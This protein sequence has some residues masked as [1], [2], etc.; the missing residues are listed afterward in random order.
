MAR[1][2]RDQSGDEFPEV[3]DFLP[4]KRGAIRKAVIKEGTAAVSTSRQ[5]LARERKKGKENESVDVRD[6]REKS[7]GS[8]IPAQKPKPRKRILKHTTDNPLLRPLTTTTTASSSE[9]SVRKSKAKTI[10]VAEKEIVL[11]PRQ[12]QPSRLKPKPEKVVEESESDGMSD[13]IVSDDDSAA[14]IG[15]SSDEEVVKTP[16]RSVRRLVRGRRPVREETP[17][18][19]LEERLGKGESDDESEE[20]DLAARIKKLSVRSRDGEDEMRKTSPTKSSSDTGLKKLS[21]RKELPPK[22]KVGA[23]SRELNNPFSTHL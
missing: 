1:L 15:E 16:P 14:F 7:M 9:L 8:E 12:T 13:F 11:K 18:D 21:T 20:D 3:S 2:A 17:E 22:K 5:L 4:S 23:A 6:E 19:K 10:F